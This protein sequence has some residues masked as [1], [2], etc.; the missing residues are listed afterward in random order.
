MSHSFVRGNWSN[1]KASNPMLLSKSCHDLDLLRWY[2][3]AR[4]VRVSSFGN[5]AWFRKENAPEGST[6]RCTD[7]CSVEPSCPYSALKI[8]YRNRSWLHHF[9][10]PASGDQGPAIMENLRSGPYGR[11]VFRSGRWRQ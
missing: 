2:V 4:C 11:C 10:L 5:L 9:D 6:A 3:N 7:G 8:Y 1:T